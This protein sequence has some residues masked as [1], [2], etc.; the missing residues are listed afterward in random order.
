MV[1]AFSRCESLTPGDEALVQVDGEMRWVA[2]AEK[3]QVRE[4]LPSHVYDL[5]V[6]DSHCFI[7]N[8]FAV[9]NTAAAV[10]DDFGEGRWTL[11]AGALVLADMGLPASM[12]STR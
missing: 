1:G 11:E 7:A 3:H 6:D 12:S 4:N 2:L 10:K 5:T 9:H 8:G